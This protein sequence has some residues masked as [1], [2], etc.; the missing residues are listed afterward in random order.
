MVALMDGLQVQWLLDPGVDM[1]GILRE[2]S[3]IGAAKVAE[4][5]A[6]PGESEPACHLELRIERPQQTRHHVRPFASERVVSLDGSISGE[7]GIGFTKSRYLAMELDTEQIALMRRGRLVLGVSSA[8][9]YGEL[10]WAEEG[11]GAFLD[12]RPIRVSRRPST[13]TSCRPPS[14]AS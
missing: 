1:A 13:S 10:A 6:V 7:H 5:P 4:R 11:R 14:T 2:S 9:A 3:N 8:C 12:G